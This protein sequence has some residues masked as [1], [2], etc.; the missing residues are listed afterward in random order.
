[1]DVARE[2]AAPALAGSGQGQQTPAMDGE[3]QAVVAIAF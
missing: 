1:M 2:L 3:S